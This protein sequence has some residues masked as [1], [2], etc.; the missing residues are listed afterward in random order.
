MDIFVAVK[1]SLPRGYELERN[2]IKVLGCFLDFESAMRSCYDDFKEHED[3][4]LYDEEDA[5]LVNIDYFLPGKG[6]GKDLFKLYIEC[7]DVF[8]YKFGKSAEW[9]INE[10]EKYS[11]QKQKIQPIKTS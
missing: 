2:T 9:C 7:T 6:K 8:V 10:T 4:D 1:L 3:M 5:E 11:V